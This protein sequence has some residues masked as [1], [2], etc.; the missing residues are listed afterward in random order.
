M[1]RTYERRIGRMQRRI[2][3]LEKRDRAGNG[4]GTA[5]A[6]KRA[7]TRAR[8]PTSGTARANRTRATQNRPSTPTASVRLGPRA[9]L[10]LQFGIAGSFVAGGSSA[11]RSDLETLLLGHHDPKQNGIGVQNVEVFFGGTVDPYFAAMGTLTVQVSPDGETEIE[12]E[13]FFATTRSLPYGLQAKAGLFYAE[14]GR[15][16]QLHLHQRAFVDA[17][18]ILTRIMGP[19]GLRNPAVRL[20]WLT[21]LPWFSEVTV[22]TMMPTGETAFSFFGEAGEDVGGF[23]RE[24][25]SVKNLRD[26]IYFVR[27][28]HGFDVSRTIA[29]KGGVSFLTGPNSTGRGNRTYIFGADIVAKWKPE[30]TQRGFP[31]VAVTLEALYRMFEGGAET[32]PGHTILRDYGFYAQAVWGFTPG[33]AAG[34]RLGWAQGNGQSS[35]DPFRNNRYRLSVNLTWIATEFSLLRLQYNHDWAPHLPGGSAHSVWLQLQISL[36]DHFAHKF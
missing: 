5:A 34:L 6:D 33:W 28:A 3:Q 9:K 23:V 29:A 8:T 18:V 4:Q 11:S 2:D 27:W 14:F 7:R 35:A 12:L 31:F 13:E 20:S 15:G 19:D 1:R 21:P 30:R 24:E 22:G 17:P 36:G 16:N 32:D 26:M 10:D 25:R